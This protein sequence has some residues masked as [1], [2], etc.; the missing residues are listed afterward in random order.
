MVKERSQQAQVQAHT[1][2]EPRVGQAASAHQS[3][4]SQ[5][6]PQPAVHTPKLDIDLFGE[7]TQTSSSVQPTTAA[8]STI[9]TRQR[10]EPSSARPSKPTE[11]LLGFDFFG[12][13]QPNPPSRPSSATSTPAS[14]PSRPDLKQSILSLYSRPSPAAQTPSQMAGTTHVQA[15]IPPQTQSN[16][17]GL[18][19]AFSSLNFT[20]PSRQSHP[21]PSRTHALNSQSQSQPAGFPG[22][23]SATSARI[24]N[25]FNAVPAQ[26][27]NHTPLRSTMSQSER[28]PSNG[29][30]D[31]ASSISPAL[32]A[33]AQTSKS[34]GLADLLGFSAPPSQFI[35]Q[36]LPRSEPQSNVDT[37][38]STFNLSAPGRAPHTQPTTYNPPSSS[39]VGTGG[40]AINANPWGSNDTWSSPPTTMS[41]ALPQI[42]SNVKSS[43]GDWEGW[44][45]QNS[46]ITP[47]APQVAADED[48]GG[49]ESSTAKSP[50]APSIQGKRAPALGG[51][52]DLFSN[53]WE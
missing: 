40:T 16:T 27:A 25:F 14:G 49:W 38:S 28:S 10:V 11:S 3:S 5:P 8:A 22:H 47:S 26:A 19:D 17:S 37:L 12:G 9:A 20:S 51:S 52:D 15:S 31:L 30:G 36:T 18:D 41:P 33:L 7:G 2:S 39:S 45:G 6:S 43:S 35:T 1:Q 24:G 44:S 32:T 4:I 42:G 50:T 46:N 48:F 13:G 53:V 21:S 29:F 23:A 34:N